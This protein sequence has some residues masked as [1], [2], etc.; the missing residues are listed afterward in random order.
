MTTNSFVAVPINFT[1]SLLQTGWRTNK[2]TQKLPL[3]WSFAKQ[4]ERLLDRARNLETC[5]HV[6]M[7]MEDTGLKE[8]LLSPISIRVKVIARD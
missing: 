2:R 4:T 7:C 3:N 5:L 8:C 1:L 6:Y